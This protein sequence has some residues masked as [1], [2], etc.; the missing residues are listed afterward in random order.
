MSGRIRDID[1]GHIKIVVLR[2]PVAQRFYAAALGGVMACGKEMQPLLTRA[3]NSLFRNFTGDKGIDARR[4]GLVD[5][6]LPAPAAP[7]NTTDQRWRVVTTMQGFTSQPLT[8]SAASCSPDRGSA[9]SPQKH[10]RH[11]FAAHFDIQ[12]FRQLGVVA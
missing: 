9:S 2:Q 3:V 11:H 10:Q 5:K 4:R 12:Q 7:G 6:A 8:D 1:E